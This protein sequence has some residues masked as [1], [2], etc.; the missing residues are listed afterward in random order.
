MN[1]IDTKEAIELFKYEQ[2]DTLSKIANNITEKFYSNK[3]YIRGLLEFSNQC[4]L[5]CLYCGIRSSNY[6]VTRYRLTDTEIVETIRNGIDKGIKTFVLQSGENEIY[7]QKFLPM[8]VEKIR[9]L[10]GDKVAITLSCGLMTKDQYRE[11]KNSGC[12]RYLMRFET[13][14]EKLYAYIKNGQTLKR[15]LKGLEELKNLGFEV[16]SGYMV[17]LPGETIDTLIDNA[18]LCQKLELDMVG[19]GPFIPHDDTPLKMTRSCHFDSVIRS[20]VLLRML[21]P[22]SNIPATTAT[23]SADDQG[24]EKVLLSGANVLMPNITPTKY[25]KDYLLY[26]GK[27]CLDESG[28]ECIDCL[29]KR[30]KTIGKEISL[31][32]GNSL[33]FEIKSK[34]KI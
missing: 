21:L 10:A 5:D 8:L 2:T 11:L 23:G 12:N 16:G 9:N 24:R 15:R 20:T 7:N 27:I 6:N 25:K 28:F 17:G 1:S 3:V 34:E 18:L 14:N 13:S 30:L 4:N 22:L 31:E 33:S 19:I 26:P 29:S 32:R